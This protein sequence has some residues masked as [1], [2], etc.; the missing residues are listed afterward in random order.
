[1][2]DRIR[3]AF[4]ALFAPLVFGLVLPLNIALRNLHE[5]PL[6]PAAGAI[7]LA[8]FL[9]LAAVSFAAHGYASRNG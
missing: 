6:T 8:L 3:W 1:M 5:L 9:V 2:F 4:A 7:F